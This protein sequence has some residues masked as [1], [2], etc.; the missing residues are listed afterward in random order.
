MP[1]LMPRRSDR[2]SAAPAKGL[3]AGLVTYQIAVDVLAQRPHQR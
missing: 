1:A 3:P 2:N